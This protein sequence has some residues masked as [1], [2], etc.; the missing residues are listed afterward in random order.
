MINVLYSELQ[1]GDFVRENRTITQQDIFLFGYLFGDVNPIHFDHEYAKTTSFN[2]VI[3]HGMILGG[4]ISMVIG[5]KLPGPGTIYLSQEINFLLP[6]YINDQLLIEVKVSSKNTNDRG[7]TLE[8]IISNQFQKVVAH[9]FAK[10]IAPKEKLSF[11]DKKIS[12][13]DIITN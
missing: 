2:D 11:K 13:N 10:V 8:C 1:V 3:A 9:G 5:T 6:V 7:V 12:I 4:L